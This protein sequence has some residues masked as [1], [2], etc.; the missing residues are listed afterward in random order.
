M[1][2]HGDVR[3]EVI[4]IASLEGQIEHL[5]ARSVVPVTCSPTKGIE[6]TCRRVRGCASADTGQSRTLPP[7]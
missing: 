4:P 7:D 3:L 6:A 2:T 5:P 1:L